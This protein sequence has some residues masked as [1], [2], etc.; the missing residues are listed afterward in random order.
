MTSTVAPPAR[1]VEMHGIVK[2]FGGTP[3]MRSAIRYLG[4]LR[5]EGVPVVVTL[6]EAPDLDCIRHWVPHGTET[7][8]TEHVEELIARYEQSRGVIGLPHTVLSSSS[9]RR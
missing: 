6:H 1:M 9:Y 2:R 5:Q 4:W 7:F 8:Y 3:F